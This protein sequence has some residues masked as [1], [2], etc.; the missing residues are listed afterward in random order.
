[1]ISNP[2]AVRKFLEERIEKYGSLQGS[3]KKNK[4]DYKF[5]EKELP[6]Q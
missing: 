2:R 6:I 4:T 1:M 3:Q 5:K